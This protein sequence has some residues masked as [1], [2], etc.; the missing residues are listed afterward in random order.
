MRN[1]TE[2]RASALGGTLEGCSQGLFACED[3]Y[4]TQSLG[5][6]AWASELWRQSL[7]VSK[8]RLAIKIPG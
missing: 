1:R 7:G 4:W 5:V 3:R 2:K 6:R 8:E